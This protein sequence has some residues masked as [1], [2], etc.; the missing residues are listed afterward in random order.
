MT[1]LSERYGKVEWNFSER[2]AQT[3]AACEAGK[4][5]RRIMRSSIIALVG[6]D[7]DSVPG[8]GWW[9]CSVNTF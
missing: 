4:V 3:L 1:S 5:H 6:T 2:A 8:R 7:W 9:E